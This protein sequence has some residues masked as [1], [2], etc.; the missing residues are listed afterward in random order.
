MAQVLCPVVI[1]RD[2]E[3]KAVDAALEAA[4]TGHGGCVVITGEPGIGKSRLVLETA[5]RAAGRG[6]RV[7][8]GRAVP[9]SATAA[10][11]PLT[12]ALVQLLR[13]GAVP[14]DTTMEPWLPALGALLP[15]MAGLAPASGAASGEFSP[16]IRGEALIQLL[17]R[18]APQG[19]VIV[20]EDLHWADPDT[21]ALLEYLGEHLEGESL[22]CVLTLRANRPSAALEAARRLRGRPGVL[23]LALDRLSDA[24]MARMVQA[25]IPGAGAEL[26]RRVQASAEGVPLLVEDLLA[27]PGLPE[28][29]TE[30]VRE[31]LAGFS[32]PQRSVIE[33]AAILGRHF[34]WE[35]LPAVSG[36]TA[37]LVAETLGLAVGQLLVSAD[38]T[39][40]RFRHALTR[41]ALLDTMLPPRQRALAA[42]ALAAL[43]AAHPRLEGGLRE[44]AADLANRAGDRRRAGTLLSESGGQALAWGALAT[45]IATLRRAADL[46]EGTPER[47]QAELVLVESLALAGRVEEAAAAGGQLI[48]RLGT[49]AAELRTEVHLR[50]SQAAVA[51]S[52]WQMA[53]HHL[54]E[55]R[56]LTGTRPPAGVRA[57]MGVLDAEVA[58][59]ADDLEEARLLAGKVLAAGDGAPDVRC[60]ALELIGRSH[61]LRDLSAARSAFESA[62]VTAETADLPLWRLRALHEL[63]TIDLFDHAGVER[64]SEARRAAEQMGALSTAAIL[65]LQLAAG[66]TCRWELDTCDAHARAAIAD[67]E[68]LGLNQVRAK[69][70]AVL[71]GSASMRADAEQ[72]ERYAAQAIAADPDDRMLD[73]FS[74][75]SRGAVLL[76]GGDAAAAVEPYARGMTILAQLP[77]AEPAGLRA[78]WPL[79]LASLGDRRAARAI[80]EARRLG[81]GA[82]RMNRSLIGYAEAV[83]AGRAGQRQRAGVLAADCDAGFTNCE[84]WGDLARFC[85]APAALAGGWGD[86]LRWLTEAETGFDRRDLPRLAEQCR[87]LLKE[88][89]PNPWVAAG[90]TARE[91]DVLRLVADGLANK[92]IAAC[93]KLSP[94]TVE[95]HVESLLR[96]T[97]A[98]SRTGLVAAA[99]P[100]AI[101]D[102]PRPSPP[103]AAT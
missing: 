10:Y 19:L 25:C 34:D 63:G 73:G 11:R 17:R 39:A 14:G 55:A 31:R 15:G 58:F 47:D 85:A 86:P 45:A 46:L 87:E 40:F 70:L 96:K 53:R 89:Q 6:I 26:L 30:T 94:R 84:A 42:A 36:Q 100:A 27:S 54:G 92:Q 77:H 67:A 78:L 69:A 72:A 52:R 43:V 41:D 12:D 93:L 99:S 79:L 32:D 33:A 65:E 103:P 57:R 50:L 29:F 97:G 74:W 66:Y 23:H 90:I 7:V 76:L 64:L 18:L 102:S 98:R 35:L 1:G 5:G 49:D 59:A 44:L 51:A 37:A 60:H 56:R 38:G 21:V 81:V 8:T 88:S 20:L 4:M 48:T 71:S 82:F 95:K 2:A 83:L 68:R 9:Q 101:R 13:D 22:L 62:L 28:S 61:R 91:A 24:D 3:L 75:A 80:E 16:G